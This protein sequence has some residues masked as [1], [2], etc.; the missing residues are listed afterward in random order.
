MSRACASTPSASSSPVTRCSCC[1][2]LEVRPLPF[3]QP[4]D[5]CISIQL[6]TAPL[7][8]EGQQRIAWR[9]RASASLIPIVPV[10]PRAWRAPSWRAC[11]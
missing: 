4:R 3:L 11:V 8:E 2:L 1:P 10:C 5:S 6:S 9:A 7:M